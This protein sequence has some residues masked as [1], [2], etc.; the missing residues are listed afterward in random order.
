MTK[1]NPK[2]IEEIVIDANIEKYEIL[3]APADLIRAIPLTEKVRETVLRG[4]KQIKDILDK[5]DS[6]KIV[7]V[8][9][10]SIHDTAA[11]LEYANNLE[12]LAAEVSDVLLIVMRTYLEKPRSTI[13][14]KGLIYDPNLDNSGD[15]RKGILIGRQFLLDVSNKG[16]Y[17]ANEF[18]REDFPQYIADLISWAAIGARTVESQTHR[19]LSSGLSMPV[20][21]KNN[22]SGDIKVAVDACLASK[23]EHGFPG[24]TIDGKICIVRTK[25][26]NYCHIVLRGGNGMSNYHP[27]KVQEAIKLIKRAGLQVNIIIDCSH[28]N[29]NKI[30]ERQEEASY[31]VLRQINEGN[32]NIVGI[33]LESNLNEGRQ[34]FPKNHEEISKLAYG[35]SI[36]DPCISWETTEKIIRKYSEVLREMNRRR[37]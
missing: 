18:V 33:M 10:C 15:I 27:E 3:P 20:G 28:A 5:K 17:C 2:T 29:C 30:Y 37:H 9:P 6:R 34:D 23:H 35:T 21:F 1:T 26:N 11:G 8:G 19:E 4:R 24:L 32:E 16:V 7:I 12:K 36:T 14:W 22:T 31:E 13:G 25:G